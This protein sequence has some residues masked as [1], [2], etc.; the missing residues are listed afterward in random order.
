MIQTKQ[1]QKG[2]QQ[3][4]NQRH[5]RHTSNDPSNGS[6]MMMTKT[7]HCLVGLFLIGSVSGFSLQSSG[8]SRQRG[9]TAA[10]AST[11][12]SSQDHDQVVQNES[13]AAASAGAVSR[14]VFWTT[15]AAGTLAAMPVL[16]AA[17]RPAMARGR[18]TLE[19]AYERYGPRIKTG[20]SFYQTE[21]KGLIAQ[22]DWKGIANAL[23]EPPSRIKSDLQ[24]VDA[25]VAERGSFCFHFHHGRWLMYLTALGSQKLNLPFFLLPSI[26]TARQA[27]AFSDARVL[28]AAELL[29]GAFSDNSISEKTKKMQVA[30][31]KV[32]TV[33]KELQAISTQALTGGETSGGGGLFG[34]GAKKTD[35]AALAKQAKTLYVEGGNA[36]NEYVAAANDSLALKFDR[37][38]YIS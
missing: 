16:L 25:G 30:I 9:T 8:S 13:S 36:W 34:M 38:S 1:K 12:S 2:T 37:F 4:K 33:V 17:P 35:P 15:A 32:R 18:A 10:A 29:A 22:S 6:R 11:S 26:I 19:Q 23:Q 14:S 28:V 27:G 20:G 31:A 3:P 24:K 7:I 5:R 21:L